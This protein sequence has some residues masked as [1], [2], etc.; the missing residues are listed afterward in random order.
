MHRA[1]GATHLHVP[2]QLPP[3][4]P[5]DPLSQGPDGLMLLLTLAALDQ[6]YQL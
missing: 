3:P 6:R 2:S 1:A 5:E 4:A